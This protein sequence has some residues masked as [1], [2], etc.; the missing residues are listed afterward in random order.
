MTCRIHAHVANV[1][2]YFVN[3]SNVAVNVSADVNVANVNIVPVTL[4]HVTLNHATL[5]YNNI[6]SA[7][8]RESTGRSVGPLNVT[9]INNQR[10]MW[11]QQ[12]MMDDWGIQLLLKCSCSA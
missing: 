4:N 5:P 3:M 6:M 9:G 1:S 11:I 8:R 10:K 12:V 7:A 2:V